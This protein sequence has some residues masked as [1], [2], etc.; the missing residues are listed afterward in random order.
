MYVPPAFSQLDITVVREFIRAYPLGLVVT[1]GPAGL[2]ANPIPCL[3]DPAGEY[4][5]LRFHLASANPQSIELGVVSECLVAFQG[6]NAYISPNW[7]PSKKESGKVVPTWNYLAVHVWGRPRVIDD[8][9]WIRRQIEDLTREQERG[10]APWHVADA[11]GHFITSQ[12]KGILGVEVD[13]D[14]VAAKW[15]LSQNRSEADRRGVA[16]GLRSETGPGGQL[17]RFMDDPALRNG[18]DDPTSSAR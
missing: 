13:I 10:T 12:Q 9:E 18:D 15:K 2:C 6:P 3:I 4:G 14:R 17:A 8:P 16:S 1:A 11:P 7:Y 5:R